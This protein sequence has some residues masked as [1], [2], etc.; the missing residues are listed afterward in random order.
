MNVLE[1]ADYYTRKKGLY[2]S[3]FVSIHSLFLSFDRIGQL[4]EYFN[5]SDKQQLEKEYQESLR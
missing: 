4:L 5:E 2:A 3:S 1:T